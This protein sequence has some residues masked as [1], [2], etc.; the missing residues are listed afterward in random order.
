M[1]RTT[2]PSLANISTDTDGSKASTVEKLFHAQ[3]AHPHASPLPSQPAQTFSTQFPSQETQPPPQKS[4]LH[5]F[6][7]LPQ[8][9][10][11]QQY[12]SAPRIPQQDVLVC[13][14]CDG[15]I[16]PESVYGMD[17]LETDTMCRA[18]GK[19][20]CNTCAIT[21]EVRLCLDCAMQG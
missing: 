11:T 21:A 16:M 8:A 6:W 7:H 18:C 17:T 3:K 19:H 13:E 1:V 10:Q 20:V 14:G 4:T 2:L 12:E 9:S 5:S 15:V